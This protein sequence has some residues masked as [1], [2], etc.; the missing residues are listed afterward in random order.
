VRAG[1]AA[2]MQVW[3]FT[4]GTHLAGQDLAAPED[5]RAALHFDRFADF[6]TLSPALLRRS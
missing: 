1:I 3:R 2:G 4:G 6:F 5:A